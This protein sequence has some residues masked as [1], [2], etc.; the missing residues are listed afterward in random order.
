MSEW[1]RQGSIVGLDTVILLIVVISARVVPMFTRN[2]TREASIRSLPR[3]NMASAISMAM[4]TI[5]D[6]AIPTHRITAALAALTGV[7]VVARTIPWGTRHTVR[8]PLLWILHV[9]SWWIPIGLF[10]R[11]ISSLSD[12]VPSSLSTHALTV[13]AVGSLTLGMMAR[14]ALGHSGR[15]LV[16]SKPTTLAFVALTASGIVRVIG[17]LFESMHTASIVVAGVLWS[18]AFVL[19]L[20]VYVP[21]LIAPRVDGKPG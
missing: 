6:I 11:A 2:A 18:L 3:L 12:T 21:I 13:G 8:D 4:F 5:C 15:M 9:G 7:V 20:V 16:V 19:Y 1:A 17:P 10:L 14:V